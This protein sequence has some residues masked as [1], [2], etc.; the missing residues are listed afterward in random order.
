MAL[1]TASEVSA[2]SQTT[3]YSRSTIVL[4]GICFVLSGATGL[5]YEVLWARMLGLVFGATT[6]AVSTVLAAFMGGLALG[7]ALAGKLAQRI[8]KP[9]SVYGVMEILIAVYAL[10]VPLLFRW[11][12]HVYAL[13][14]QQLQPGYF[15]FSLWRF[16]L[17]GAVL[18]VPTTL[19]GA[20]LPV[21]AAALVRSAGRDSN[22][23]TRL[24]A[25]NLA[26]AI[27]GTLA[28]GFVLLPWLGVRT[29]I[30][31]AAALNIIV[32]VIAIVLQHRAQSHAGVA[33][34]IEVEDSVAEVDGRGFW[35]FAALVSGFVTIGTQVSWTRVLTMIIGSSTYAFS[36]VVALFLIGLAIGAWIVARKDRS[37]K[38]RSTILVVEVLTALSLL[39]SLF[40]L[41]KI[42]GLLIHLGLR[43]QVASWTGLLAL[44]ILCATLLILVPAVLMG[45]VMPLV[46][47]WASSEGKKA[48]ARVGRSYAI[49]TVG[50]IAGA[51]L[52]GF[53]LIPKA[54]TR[55]T[56]LFAS[57]CCLIVAGVA[58]RPVSTGLDP[59]LKRSLAIG[60]TFVAIIGAFI[61]APR[62]NLAD[63]SIGAYDSLVRVIAQTR[64]GV[65]EDVSSASDVHELLMYEE[66]PTAT[67]SVRRDQ[68]TVSMAING[69]T[70]AS[71]SIYDMPTQVM[72]GQL[73]LL[74]A[75]R[76]DNGLIIGYATGITVGAMLQ[77]P[78]QSVT[79][80]E[81]EQ[82][83][84]AGSEFFNHINNR[85]LDD[86]RT[87]LII[88]DAR[89][90]LRVTPNRYDM[91]VSE[92]SHPWVPGVANLFTQEFFELGRARLTDDG[93]W[94]QWVQI[95]QL[96]TES[97]RSVLATYHRVFPHV[98]VFRVGGL[99]KGKDLLL[100]GSNQP[101]NLD[102]LSER[103]ADPRIATELARVDLKSEA[104]VRG[105]FVCDESKLGPAVAGA[106]INTDDNMHI[107]MTVPRE[108]FRPLMQSNAEWVQ[109]LGK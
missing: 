26:G 94:V 52:T 70:N 58:Y 35:F 29:T 105:W 61:V 42:P 90:F 1:H 34:Q 72:L 7:S 65:K 88:D 44:Q 17:S 95:Y 98:L 49:N 73:P 16:S 4:I 5:I 109:A 48:V 104:D 101:L 10:L 62:M 19:M 30:A 56:L 69:R 41:N 39:F 14:W 63:L 31:V 103:F 80:V 99:N 86:P 66:G 108:A 57:T 82:G 93:I 83:T 75:P 36:I 96:S 81:L 60:I 100:I 102:R 50:A 6:L 74:I 84:V 79:C 15:T 53:I 13:I 87:K 22:S 43:L 85:P 107:E 68:D 64:E 9:L 55:F 27:L 11:I 59:A 28:A 38:L 24:Y 23:V 37:S 46:L 92:P 2:A 25:C 78:I 51:F 3:A 47:V 97:L 18:L 106:K 45:I 21:L 67:V 20:T 33:E 89:T 76:I 40:V 77:S 54:S 8:R 12:D 32:G 91:I 71:D